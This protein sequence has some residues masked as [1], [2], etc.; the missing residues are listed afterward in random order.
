MRRVG[1]R[2]LG[3]TTAWVTSSSSRT[4]AASRLRC[5]ERK[6]DDTTV[7]APSTSRERSRW[8]ASSFWSAVST[9]VPVSDQVSSTRVSVVLTCWPPAPDERENRQV[10]SLSGREMRPL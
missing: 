10:I 7:I 5:C 4:R 1:R 2:G 9:V 8:A 3:G 6:R